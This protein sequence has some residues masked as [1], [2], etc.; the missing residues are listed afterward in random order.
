MVHTWTRDKDKRQDSGIDNSQRKV[1]LAMK[2]AAQERWKDGETETENGRG[3]QT[4]KKVVSGNGLK[5]GGGEVGGFLKKT[6][7][8][9]AAPG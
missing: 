9:G 1:A 6:I 8:E 7:L 4:G 5:T 3:C 2:W